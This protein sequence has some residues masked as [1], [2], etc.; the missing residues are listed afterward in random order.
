MYG[1]VGFCLSCEDAIAYI[2]KRCV[3][4]SLCV[5]CHR[6]AVFL[7]RRWAAM[8][9]LSC[10]ARVAAATRGQLGASRVTRLSVARGE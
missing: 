8:I 9:A 4:A 2:P 1:Q 6:M 5:F 7:H 10:E 3:R